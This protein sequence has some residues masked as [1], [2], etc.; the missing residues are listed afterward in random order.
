MQSQ[1]VWQYLIHKTKTIFG[2][3]DDTERFKIIVAWTFPS[4]RKV[5]VLK[6]KRVKNIG[7]GMC[8]LITSKLRYIFQMVVV[9]YLLFILFYIFLGR[10]LN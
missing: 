9:F 7:L 2:G 5:F 3:K 8:L 1:V 10:R 6:K 4:R